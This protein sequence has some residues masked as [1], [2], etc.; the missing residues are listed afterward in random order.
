MRPSVQKHRLAHHL[1]HFGLVVVDVI[2]RAHVL[3]WRWPPLI[4]C[5]PDD[6]TVPAVAGCLLDVLSHGGHG[7]FM[8][9]TTLLADGGRSERATLST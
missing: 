8:L 5:L 1:A 9:V 7:R 2:E 6:S 3:T 4:T